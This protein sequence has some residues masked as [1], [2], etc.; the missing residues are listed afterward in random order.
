MLYN[1]R[2]QDLVGTLQQEVDG[3][4]ARISKDNAG[5]YPIQA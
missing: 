1:F 5:K 3:S 2:I 4:Y